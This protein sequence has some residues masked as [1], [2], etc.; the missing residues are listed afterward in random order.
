FMCNTH[1]R[2]VNVERLERQASGYVAK[3]EPN[4]LK[5]KTPWFRGV[6]LKYGPDGCIYLS[7]W[8]DYGECHD[9][10]GVHRTSGR[11]YRISC[12]EPQKPLWNGIPVSA[13]SIDELVRTATVGVPSGNEWYR[14]HARRLLLEREWTRATGEGALGEGAATGAEPS[15]QETPAGKELAELVRMPQQA[16]DAVQTFQVLAALGAVDRES[17]ADLVFHA[18]EHVQAAA[19]RHGVD[20]GFFSAPPPDPGRA[21]TNADA[22]DAT[23]LLQAA[24]TAE[25]I[26]LLTLASSLQ[27]MDSRTRL[28]T[29][30]RLIPRL[31]E[32]DDRKLVLMTWYGLVDETSP[33]ALLYVLSGGKAPPLLLQFVARRVVQLPGQSDVVLSQLLSR[34]GPAQTNEARIAVLTGMLEGLRGQHKPA[35]P[36]SWEQDQKR[37]LASDNADVVRL[38]KQLAGLYGDGAALSDLRSLVADRNG[39]HAARS[40]AV[41]ALAQA[42]D[43]DS[44]P[45]F[46]SLLNDRAVY[47]DVARGLASY[48][49]PRVPKDLIRQWNNLR[50][51]AKDAAM[52][53]LCSRRNYAEEL[54]RALADNRISSEDISAAQVRQLLAFSSDD[55]NQVIHAKWGVINESSAARAAVM[56]RLKQELTGEVLGRADHVA[57][58][59]LFKKSCGACHRL[60]GDGGQI[61]P[62]LTGSNRGNLDYLLTNIIE[63]SAVVPKQFTVSVILL[64]SGRVVTGVV[65]GETEQSISVQTDKELLTISKAD[66]EERTLTTKSLMP[67]G[68][69]DT[70][71]PEQIRDLFAFVMHRR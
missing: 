46:L 70:L 18:D 20:S 50:H 42:E 26:A 40:Q 66:I 2:C 63:P 9:H 64:T 21:F 39:D 22:G 14:R 15:W 51:G 45:L 6:D 47:V 67:D 16:E 36:P 28:L 68:L 71:S 24:E 48:N 53:T 58:A 1:G 34:Y 8:S 62:D 59:A 38:T 52:D 33:A 30:Q 5:V 32:T 54:A 31:S 49:D 35:S 37:L 65:V 43:A 23:P 57:G 61:G 41:A 55:I 69:L 11:I 7:D 60:Y 44:L 12:G 13:L 17:C 3:H 19:I 27:R 4:L 29:A 25:G 56:E 10:D